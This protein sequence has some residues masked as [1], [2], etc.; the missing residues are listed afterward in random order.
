LSSVFWLCAAIMRRSVLGV[1][2]LALSVV[3]SVVVGVLSVDRAGDGERLRIDG[4]D[5]V[6]SNLSDCVSVGVSLSITPTGIAGAAGSNESTPHIDEP[7][8]TASA[9]CAIGDHLHAHLPT[10]RTCSNSNRFSSISDSTRVPNTN[11][12]ICAR[13]CD[14]T[15]A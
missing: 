3:G 5:A 6:R 15:R 11:S 13:E 1:R 12:S 10:R 7:R 14:H 9:T 8:C 2:A 4:D